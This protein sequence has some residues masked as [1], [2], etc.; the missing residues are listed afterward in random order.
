MVYRHDL[1]MLFSSKWLG[2][3]ASGPSLWCLGGWMLGRSGGCGVV[4]GCMGALLGW[5]SVSNR[6]GSSTVRR[7]CFKA[8]C[9]PYIVCQ[10]CPRINGIRTS[11]CNSSLRTNV[12]KSRVG[13]HAIKT[14]CAWIFPSTSGFKAVLFIIVW[15]AWPRAHGI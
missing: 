4:L 1:R 14:T 7:A 9:F 8:I 6:M 15:L 13:N 10:A 12:A 11:F 5:N 3:W 2:G